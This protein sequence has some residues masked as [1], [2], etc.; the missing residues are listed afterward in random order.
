MTMLRW[1]A[2]GH[3]FIH[4]ETK[5]TDMKPL[6][7]DHTVATHSSPALSLPLPLGC[8]VTTLWLFFLGL[9]PFM[10]QLPPR[11][12]SPA[13]PSHGGCLSVFVPHSII[14]VQ[15]SCSPMIP[16]I[17]LDPS[18]GFLMISLVQAFWHLVKISTHSWQVPIEWWVL[19]SYY[20]HCGNMADW[21]SGFG[22][23]LFSREGRL[24]P[25]GFLVSSSTE[26]FSSANMP[27]F[28][29]SHF[30][31]LLPQSIC[32]PKFYKR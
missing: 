5:S 3:H 13:S 30:Q 11:L 24:S 17:R 27:S 21:V 12:P 1:A 31:L 2:C 8:L 9:W 23:L 6:A 22:Q 14:S 28:I 20:R 26:L 15:S 16:K 29:L 19:R 7:L 32:Y 4:R 18:S 25:T 10:C